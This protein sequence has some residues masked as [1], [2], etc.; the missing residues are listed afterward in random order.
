[1][2]GGGLS[3]RNIAGHQDDIVRL[4]M[5]VYYIHDT[6]VTEADIYILLK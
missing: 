1:M 2:G 5:P 3:A 6:V 4:M